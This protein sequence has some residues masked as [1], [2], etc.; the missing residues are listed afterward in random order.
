MT[1]QAI[2]EISIKTAGATTTYALKDM[3]LA[4]EYMLALT[5]HFIPFEVSYA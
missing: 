2:T 3:E 4:K 1:N 5:A